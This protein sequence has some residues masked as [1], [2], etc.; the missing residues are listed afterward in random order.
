MTRQGRAGG[1][2]RQLLLRL[3]AGATA[4]M[5]VAGPAHAQFSQG[6]KFLEAVK[7]KEGQKVE[8]ALAIPGST[9]INTRDVT[10]GE[11][12][13][14]I[15]TQRRDI[16][17][18]TF[19]VAKGA[20][21]NVRDARGV[22]P[23]QLASNLGWLDGVQLLVDKKAR[24]DDANDAGETPL[25]FAVH[26]RDIPMMRVLLKAGADPDRKDNSGRSARDYA[27]LSG[28]SGPLVTEIE[29]SAKPRG[30]QG[31]TYGPTF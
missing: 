2:G 30:Q 26:R 16:T 18:L 21:V 22:T 7:K 10:T 17:W 23:L 28:R 6:Y 29:S 5:L 14:H 31:A 25:I 8:D 1:R 4:T 3:L 20:N 11:T 24:V 27:T 9:I 19:L 13:L 12:A 15:V